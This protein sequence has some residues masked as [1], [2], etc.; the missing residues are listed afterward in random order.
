ML[1]CCH[2]LQIPEYISNKIPRIQ[3]DD[4]W[5]YDP[6]PYSVLDGEC[7]FTD[8]TS[9]DLETKEPLPYSTIRSIDDTIITKITWYYE[10]R[11][12]YKHSFVVM[13]PDF[14]TCAQAAHS[15]LVYI[16]EKTNMGVEC[17]SQPL[18]EATSRLLHDGTPYKRN[19]VSVLMSQTVN[20][21]LGDVKEAS[22]VLTQYD[23]LRENC[24]EYVRWIF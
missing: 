12:Y 6:S 7:Y 10:H 13:E 14:E 21:R 17:Y 24:H 2:A 23:M 3:F 20:M 18:L 4:D 9:H 8:H 22:I 15:G 5:G 11:T 1:T 19:K 16:T